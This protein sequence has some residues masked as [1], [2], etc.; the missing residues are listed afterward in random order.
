[1]KTKYYQN[2][3]AL[4]QNLYHKNHVLFPNP[5]PSL[6]LDEKTYLSLI[7]PYTDLIATGRDSNGDHVYPKSVPFEKYINFGNVDSEISVCFHILISA[8]EKRLRAYLITIFSEKM[9]LSGDAQCSRVA[10]LKDYYEKGSLFDLLP[11]SQ[12]LTS[13]ALLPANVDEMKRRREVMDEI[14]N[15]STPTS[16]KRPSY[17]ACH[18]LET[19]GYIP[20]FVSLHSLG[21]GSLITLFQMLKRE[22][23]KAFISQI[24]DA[25]N[26][27]FNDNE[28]CIFQQ[29]LKTINVIRNIVNHYEPIFP[30]ILHYDLNKISRLCNL[31]SQLKSN[32]SSTMTAPKILPPIEALITRPNNYNK[33]L[34]TRLNSVI[35]A[36]Q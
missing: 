10:V 4:L 31:I 2:K 36:L 1:M 6:G 8:F 9:R 28:I 32:L 33:E 21:L 29:N 34:F 14:V 22:D 35:T 18:Y 20:L 15:F 11:Y 12:E 30:F 7:T 24:D 5:V 25:G 17:I 23:K 13:G 19:Y 3:K 16:T 27:L 26:H